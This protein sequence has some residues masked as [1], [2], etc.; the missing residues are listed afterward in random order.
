M[1]RHFKKQFNY[2]QESILVLQVNSWFP[3]ISLL[4][5][6]KNKYINYYFN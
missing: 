6:K 5:P 1:F 3:C 2:P 4:Q